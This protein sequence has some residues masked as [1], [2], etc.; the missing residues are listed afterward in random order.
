MKRTFLLLTVIAVFT[1]SLALS[2]TAAEHGE[3]HMGEGRMEDGR[4]M[5]GGR[6][7]G[8]MMEEDE[9]MMEGM[10][11]MRQMMARMMQ[12]QMVAAADGGVFVM[13]GNML[14]KYD[15]NLELVTK[16]ELEVSEEDMEKMKDHHRRC[17]Q[18]M[19]KMIDEEM[20]ETE[21]H[22]DHH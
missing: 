20:D 7:R 17:R 4:M 21:D 14:H 3:G 13:V 22:E 16:T 2:A 5:R 15:E 6:M 10:P 8:M 12:P 11:M 19:R 1:T 18:M 9:E